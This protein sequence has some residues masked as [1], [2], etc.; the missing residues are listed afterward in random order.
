MSLIDKN[1]LNKILFD[2]FAS[3]VNKLNPNIEL[4]NFDGRVNNGSKRNITLLNDSKSPLNCLNCYSNKYGYCIE[5]V[6]INEKTNEIPTIEI[7]INGM[8]LKVVIATW[9]ALNT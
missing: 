3:I 2:F 6:P 1:E 8:N 7:L 5:T 9:N 4:L